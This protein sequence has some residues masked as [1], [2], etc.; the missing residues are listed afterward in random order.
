V[1]EAFARK[2]FPGEQAV[3]QILKRDGIDWHIVGVCRDIKYSDIKSGIPPTVY[4]SFRQKATGSAFFALRTALPPLAVATA[5]RRI[6][7]GLDPNIPLTDLGTQ[8]QIR[9]GMITQQR[10]FALLCSF[11]ALLAV[12]LSCIGLY[13]L[14]AYHVSRRIG[15]IGIR[16]ALGATRGRIAGPILREALTLGAI[17]VTVGVAL[18]LA[19]SGLVKSQLYGVEPNGAWTILSAGLGLVLVALA[20]A[21]IPARRAARVNPMV[22]LRTE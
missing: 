10:L 4:L 11:L 21:W 3:G 22:A 12:L 7:A 2:F 5:A 17:G 1:N 6:V 14:I 15:E 20:S 9:N 13:G 19:L 18:A 8:T 16:M